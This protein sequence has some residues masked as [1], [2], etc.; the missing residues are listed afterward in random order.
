MTSDTLVCGWLF[1]HAKHVIMHVW[2]FEH[3][4]H[5]SMHVVQKDI[6]SGFSNNSEAFTSELQEDFEEMVPR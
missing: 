5:V 2:L 4:K 6:F 1:E 3:A